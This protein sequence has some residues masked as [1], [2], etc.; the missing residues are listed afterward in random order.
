MPIRSTQAARRTRDPDLAQFDSIATRAELTE[1]GI[2][3]HQID[4]QLSARRWQRVGTAIVLHNTRLT[5]AQCRRAAL[6]NCGPRA[7]L[8][9]FTAA[10]EWGLRSW[11]RPEI[12]VLAP[13]GTRRPPI[14]GLRLHRTGDWSAAELVP[15]RHL[16]RLAPALVLAAS[17]FPDP[18]PG[19]GLLAAAV[20]QRLTRPA[21]LYEALHAAPRT[22]HRAALLTAIG[23]IAQGAQ[24]LAEIDFGRL[25]KR[26]GL[27]KPTRQ[28]IRVEPNGRRRYLDAEWRLPDGRI[29]AVEVDGAL[30]MRQRTWIDDQLR[31][32]Q[33]VLGGT[34]VLRYASVVVRHQPELVAA[35]LARALGVTLT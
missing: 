16:H 25:C 35:Q 13:A 17:S 7:V 12:H 24:S 15:L 4:T 8:T 19:C 14:R 3:A 31:L 18:R 29:V 2:T 23:D 20:Q 21:E 27:P 1:L 5:P 6:I 22:R 32:N 11:E 33:I 28:A 9:S 26:F 30:H 34:T 10:A